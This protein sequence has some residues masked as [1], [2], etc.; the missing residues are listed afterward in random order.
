MTTAER[1][2]RIASYMQRHHDRLVAEGN[3]QEAEHVESLLGDVAAIA[4]GETFES[5][6]DSQISAE[7]A[8]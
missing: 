6:V 2:T 4:G 5:L 7:I 1:I 8:L 3:A